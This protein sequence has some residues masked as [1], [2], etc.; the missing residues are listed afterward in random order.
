MTYDV[1]GG[2]LNLALSNSNQSCLSMAAASAS[3]Q[4]SPNMR[5]SFTTVPLQLS[6]A[7]T[8]LS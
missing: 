4:T 6:L 2:R 3:F 8:V 1:F 7:N 5:R